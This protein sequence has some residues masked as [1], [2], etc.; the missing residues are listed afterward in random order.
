MH[1]NK[2]KLRKTFLIIRNL[3]DP[4]YFPDI[5][6]LFYKNKDFVVATVFQKLFRV[7]FNSVFISLLT[8]SSDFMILSILKNLKFK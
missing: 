8:E 7:I 1:Y 2:I 6:E 4:I 5:K 3:G